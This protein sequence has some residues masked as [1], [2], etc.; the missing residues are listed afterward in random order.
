[1]SVASGGLAVAFGVGGA[2]VLMGGCAIASADSGSSDSSHSSDTANRHSVSGSERSGPA[3]SKAVSAG[4]AS[5]KPSAS[6][7]ASS[8]GDASTVADTTADEP[9]AP[10]APAAGLGR[11]KSARIGG[12]SLSSATLSRRS[13]ASPSVVT[14]SVTTGTADVVPTTPTAGATLTTL[15][16]LS[17]TQS[18][19]TPVATAPEPHPRDILIAV[20]TTVGSLALQL[21]REI[22]MATHW[23]GPMPSSPTLTLNGYNLLPSSTENVTSFYGQWSNF[24]GGPTFVQG[25]QEFNVVDPATSET[26]GTFGALVSSGTPFA[27]LGPLSFGQYKEI[28]VTS[29]NAGEQEPPVGGSIIA[30]Q[31][32]GR[33]GWSYSALREPTGTV[34]S[35]KLLT[36]FGDLPPIPMTFDA[37]ELMEIRPFSSAMD[38]AWRR[39]TR[40]RQPSSPRAACFPSSRRFR[41]SRSSTSTIRTATW[42]VAS[43]ASIPPRPMTCWAPTRRPSSSRAMTALTSAPTRVRCRPSGPFTTCC[44]KVVTIITCS[45]RRC[46]PCRGGHRVAARHLS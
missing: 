46:P 43:K 12:P 20:V 27:F 1:M 13:G 22:S 28:L 15:S 30:S 5:K 23:G 2:G 6:A 17:T 24:P 10:S 26:V 21:G 16:G 8:G 19:L 11:A 40:R 37:T 3:R 41:A 31:T 45:T 35:F 39:R 38:T 36:P 14:N 44:T 25:T 32:F 42:S 29:N 4:K 7:A 9:T 33:F 18:S 34:V